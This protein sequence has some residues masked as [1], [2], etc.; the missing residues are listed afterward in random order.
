MLLQEAPCL[1]EACIEGRLSYEQLK[2]LSEVGNQDNAEALLKEVEGLSYKH[3]YRLIQAIKEVD[4]EDDH[5]DHDYRTLEMRWEDRSLIL[6][7]VLP[8]DKGVM[9]EEVIDRLARSL[10]RE[11]EGEATIDQLRADALHELASGNSSS[12]TSRPE[13]V[14][15]VDYQALMTGGPNARLEGGPPISVDLARMLMCDSR[16]RYLVEDL[17]GHPIL[18]TD[19]GSTIPGSVRRAVYDRDEGSCRFPGCLRRKGLHVHHITYSSEDGK[20]LPGNL[21]TLCDFHHRYVHR[22]NYRIHGPPPKV[23]IQ[24]GARPREGW[25]SPDNPRDHP[26]VQRRETKAGPPADL[27]T[28]S[29]AAAPSAIDVDHLARTQSGLAPY[30]PFTRTSRIPPELAPAGCRGF[31]PKSGVG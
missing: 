27:A 23:S 29:T 4:A 1:K 2:C 13:V 22:N 15:H 7:C 28:F 8:S 5:Y 17:D 30:E 19:A 31:A 20:T 3:T 10:P 26:A 12:N 24:T 14:V 21:V 16:V 6:F 11:P 18:V 9:V 25:A